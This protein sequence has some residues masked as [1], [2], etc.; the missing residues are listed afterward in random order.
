VP[1]LSQ[2]LLATTCVTALACAD[3]REQPN[4]G[5]LTPVQDTRPVRRLAALD[6][7]LAVPGIAV[8]YHWEASDTSGSGQPSAKYV[9]P[10]SGQEITLLDS[11]AF[12]LAGAA[13]AVADSSGPAYSVSLRTSPTGREQLIATTTARQG[14]RIGVLVNGRMVTLAFVQ[15]PLMTMLPVVARVPQEQARAL[16]DRINSR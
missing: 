13:G 3:Q 7:A 5:A 1:T 14:D 15:S 4:T 12:S 16:A 8:E 2:I 10:E 6:S 11:I 9:D